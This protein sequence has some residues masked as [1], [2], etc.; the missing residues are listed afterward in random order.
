[1]YHPTLG[2]WMQR[3]PA[4]TPQAPPMARNVSGAQFTQRDSVGQY[5][6]GM[7]LYQY[8]SGNPLKYTDP[9]GLWKLDRKNQATA[10]AIANNS[11]DTVEK[12]ALITGLDA[13]EWKKWLQPENSSKASSYLIREFGGMHF[14]CGRFKVP[15]TILAS[16]GG[17]EGLGQGVGM[18]Y[19]MW[20]K[21]V[22]DLEAGGFKVVERRNPTAWSLLGDFQGLSIDKELQ[23]F[24]FWGHGGP[25]GLTT[26][27]SENSTGNPA[28]QLSYA[29]VR[30]ALSYKLGFLMVYSCYGDA[31]GDPSLGNLASPNARKWGG[32]G[33]L[34]PLPF[35]LS[36]P[37]VGQLLSTGPQPDK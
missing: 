7:N 36:A 14:A 11:Y 21:D 13:A 26:K 18:A 10:V 28:Y 8:V 30:G 12:L 35:H 24:L 37:T 1:M 23:G 32:H 20:G 17:W 6:D 2:R 5:R 22:G 29:K 4:G 33:T 9:A 27:E 19:V 16:W 25:T 34:V 15:N 31:A 3:D